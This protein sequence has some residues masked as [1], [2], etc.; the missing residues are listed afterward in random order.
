[1]GFH[2]PVRSALWLN[3]TVPYQI[4][5]SAFP[6]G[7]RGR[8]VIEAAMRHISQETVIRFIPRTNHSWFLDIEPHPSGQQATSCN[9]DI[10]A[11]QP[12]TLRC[13]PS[14]N[15]HFRLIVHELCHAIGLLHEAQRPD[16][17]CFITVD[18]TASRLS[19]AATNRNFDIAGGTVVGPYDYDSITHYKRTEFAKTSRQTIV[20]CPN[21]QL[22]ADP[23]RSN[24]PCDPNAIEIGES[25]HLSNGDISTLSTAY[26]IPM[27]YVVAWQDDSPQYGLYD[28]RLSAYSEH[29]KRVLGE[30]KVNSNST[31]QQRLP[32]VAVSSRLQPIVVWEDDADRNGLYQ[33]KCKVFNSDGS[34]RLNEF[35][36]NS[37]AAGQQTRPD[38]ACNR[39]GSFVVVWQ[40]DIQRNGRASIK[41]KGFTSD[42]RMRFNDRL[43]HGA[44]ANP[45]TKPAV[46]GNSSGSFAVAWQSTENGQTVIK[47]R[48]FFASG[49]PRFNTRRITVANRNQTVR[50]AITMTARGEVFVAWEHAAG[51]NRIDVKMRGFRADGTNM[52]PTRTVHS[53]RAGNQLRPSIDCAG[54]RFVVVSWADDVDG[55]G[56]FEVMAA[57][58]DFNGRPV[59]SA[60]QTHTVNPRGDGNQH[61]PAVGAQSNGRYA[62][63]WQDTLADRGQADVYIRSYTSTARDDYGGTLKVSR[64]TKFRQVNPV[65]AVVK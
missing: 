32:G 42:G 19:A 61:G 57:R 65:M 33:I 36:V 30:I 63:A 64:T 53:E 60:R 43:V 44:T 59:G 5:P 16:R 14:G 13:S 26:Q 51:V 7:S 6:P 21:P 17:D 24:Q 47:M 52:F 37:V 62:V 29:G 48:A 55:N 9:S 2:T 34:T 22:C 31:G 45:Q 35:T 38:V 12:T 10:G 4:D 49:Q 40:D 20:P 11:Q 41:M 1:M 56:H 3:A 28:I 39:F 18:K 46:A 8:N 58:F 15:Q 27:K 23:A 54:S 50:P 25:P